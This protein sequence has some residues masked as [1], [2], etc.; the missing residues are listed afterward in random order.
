MTIEFT[1]TPSGRFEPYVP[2]PASAHRLKLS[3]RIDFEGGGFLEGAGVFLD[4]GE[5]DV[6]HPRAAELLVSSFN[7]VDTG[8][9]TIR[10]LEVVRRAS[11]CA[12]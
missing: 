10:S 1:F 11:R 2:Q 9:V 12:R 7:L 8:P 4:I 6:C 5:A 3:F